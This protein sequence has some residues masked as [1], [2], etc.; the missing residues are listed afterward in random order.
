M[1][2]EG[3]LERRVE[4]IDRYSRK[5]CGMQQRVDEMKGNRSVVE[6]KTNR[7]TERRMKEK[8]KPKVG[9][10]FQTFVSVV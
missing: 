10:D 4:S 5:D 2:T 8:E 3:Y 6:M 7:Q 1:S 9:V